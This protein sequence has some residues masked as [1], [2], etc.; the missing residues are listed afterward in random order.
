MPW[1]NQDVCAGCGICVDYCPTGAIRQE[2][3][4]IALIDDDKCIR[5]GKCHSVCPKEAVRH[6]SEKIPELVEQNITK[7]INLLDRYKNHSD[8]Q[9]LIERMVKHFNLHKKVATLTIDRINTL[10]M[11]MKIS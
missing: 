1:I 8:K 6:D 9:R 4:G 11:N 10:K 3:T 5:C 7:T 2:K